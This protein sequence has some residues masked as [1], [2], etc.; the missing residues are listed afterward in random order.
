MLKNPRESH[1]KGVNESDPLVFAKSGGI[2]LQSAK[3]DH[4]VPMQKRVWG[5]RIPSRFLAHRITFFATPIVFPGPILVLQNA[6]VLA[7]HEKK[8]VPKITRNDFFCCNKIFKLLMDFFFSD[9]WRILGTHFFHIL[10]GLLH[11]GAPKSDREKR[12]LWGK[13]WCGAP[14]NARGSDLSTP[15]LSRE[16]GDSRLPDAKNAT[17]FCKRRRDLIFSHPFRRVNVAI[18]VRRAQKMQH[19]FANIEGI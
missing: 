12:W 1:K 10:R 17:R 4:H 14:R 5:N 11:F 6:T 16:N 2:F 7:E 18:R 19:D 9:F 8:P 15:F 13:K 3:M